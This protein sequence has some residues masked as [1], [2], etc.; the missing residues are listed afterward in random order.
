M[1]A[2][3]AAVVVDVVAVSVVSAVVAAVV[4]DVVAVS[5]VSAAAAVTLVVAVAADLS[6]EQNPEIISFFFFTRCRKK[7]P[8]LRWFLVIRFPMR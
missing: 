5:V 4:V 8:V 3:V 1:G 7:F 2:V 6:R